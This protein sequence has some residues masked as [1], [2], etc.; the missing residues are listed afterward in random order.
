MHLHLFYLYLLGCSS[1]TS[2]DSIQLKI[3]SRG[4]GGSP[5]QATEE[6]KKITNVICK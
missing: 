4:L 3:S 1:G 5:T 2:S 6:L